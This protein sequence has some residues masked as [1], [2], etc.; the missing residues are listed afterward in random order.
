MESEF[1]ASLHYTNVKPSLQLFKYHL[2]SRNAFK[3]FSAVLSEGMLDLLSFRSA[4]SD[5]YR[6]MHF[7]SCQRRADKGGEI[8]PVNNHFD[9]VVSRYRLTGYLVSLITAPSMIDESIQPKR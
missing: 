8:V 1:I 7:P 5:A 3:T 2:D 4:V 9:N 6:L